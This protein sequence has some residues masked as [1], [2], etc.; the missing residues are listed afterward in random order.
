M[1]VTRLRWVPK[2]AFRYRH[3]V[4]DI[5]WRGRKPILWRQQKRTVRMRIRHHRLRLI[6]RQSHHGNFPKFVRHIND[7]SG[8]PRPSPHLVIHILHR[9][10]VSGLLQ[11]LLHRHSNPTDSLVSQQRTVAEYFDLQDQ[12]VLLTEKLAAK[13]QVAVEPAC[14]WTGDSKIW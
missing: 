1:P 11:H 10:A 2:P 6:R 12:S 9:L 13:F 8:L 14:L 4:P 7:A 5:W 3:W